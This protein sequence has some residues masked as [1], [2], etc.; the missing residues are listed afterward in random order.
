LLVGRT[1]V[2]I[3]HIHVP[4]KSKPRR[5]VCKVK[6]EAFHQYLSRGKTSGGGERETNLIQFWANKRKVTIQIRDIKRLR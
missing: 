6:V 2:Y 4:G 3:K 5:E 1:I